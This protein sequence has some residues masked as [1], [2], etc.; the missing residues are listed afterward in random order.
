[1]LLRRKPAFYRPPNRPITAK[2]SLPI[3]LNRHPDFDY[4]QIVQRGTTWTGKHRRSRQLVVV[5]EVS[6][7]RLTDFN[8]FAGVAHVNVARQLGV[9]HVKS[10]AYLAYEYVDL[11]VLEALPLSQEEI[12]AVVSQAM[13]AIDYLRKRLTFRI[14][15]IRITSGGIVKIGK[16][17][18]SSLMLWLTLVV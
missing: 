7:T 5:R 6:H 4:E 18:G 1:M 3:Y 2:T 12:S 14:D 16:I 9:Y 15:T 8:R 10:Q 17:Q 11:D 13:A